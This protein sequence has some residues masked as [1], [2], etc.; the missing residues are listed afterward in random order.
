MLS[1]SQVTT[2]PP[3][4]SRKRRVAYGPGPDQFIDVYQPNGVSRGQVISIHGGYWR[5]AYGLDLNDPIARHLADRGWS[6]ANVEYR[7]IEPGGQPVWNHMADDLI[8][9]VQSAN[10][11]G[12]AVAIGHSAGGQLALWLATQAAAS[13]T[14]VVALAPVTD[15]LEADRQALSDHATVALFGGTAEELPEQYAAASP[16]SHLPLGV[17]QLVVHGP[18]DAHVP[19]SLA[20]GYVDAARRHGDPVDL[21]APTDIDHFDVIDPS[22]DVWRS[23]DAWMDRLRPTPQI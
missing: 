4:K 12:G 11:A 16:R 5:S 9:A 23:I 1:P 21:L 10:P 2:S 13:V 20:A 6:V 15:L 19:F 18:S 17:A 7:R 8:A 14:A 3:Q 22:H